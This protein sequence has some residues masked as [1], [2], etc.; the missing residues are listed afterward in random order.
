MK[1]PFGVI[2]SAVLLFMGTLLQL[3]L[4]AGMVLAGAYLPMQAPSGG[5]PGTTEPTPMASMMHGFMYVCGA[6]LVA[7]ALWGILTA[8]GLLRLRRWAR[9]SIL[10]IGGMSALIGL[11]SML[12]TLLALMAPLP[13][14]SGADASQAHMYARIVIGVIAIFYGIPCAVGI[15]WLVY[16]NRKKVRETFAGATG[17]ALESRRPLLISV[18]AI[19][20]MIGT[21]SCLLMGFLPIPAVIFGWTPHG[22][23]KAIFLIAFAV[24]NTAAGI[25]LWRLEEWGRRLTLGLIAYGVA[26]CLVYLAFPSVLLRYEAELHQMMH[27]PLL[28]PQ[29]QSE[30]VMMLVS[31]GFSFLFGIAIAAILVHYRGAFQRAIEPPPNEPKALE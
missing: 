16:F 26:N 7:M 17:E 12:I 18:I 21:V 10:V 30:N 25:G 24:L 15:F 22:W 31:L 11:I 2:L 20:Y 29:T 3:L 23:E 14:T 27:L 9:Y 8:I 1:R 4:A 6:F 5:V 13:M 19:L 28:Q